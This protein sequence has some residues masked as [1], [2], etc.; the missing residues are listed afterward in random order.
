MRAVSRVRQK[1]ICP[2]ESQPAAE[3]DADLAL[4]LELVQ[5]LPGKTRLSARDIYEYAR[6]API[7]KRSASWALFAIIL[8]FF[9][10]L[11]MALFYANSQDS[12]AAA[13]RQRRRPG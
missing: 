9:L 8:V 13:S 6:H 10:L 7:S 12:T 1:A 3:G 4:T 2:D 5:P 11:P